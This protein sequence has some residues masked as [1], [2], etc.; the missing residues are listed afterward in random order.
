[1]ERF[2]FKKRIVHI[3]GCK[4]CL[5]NPV[6]LHLPPGTYRVQLIGTDHGGRHNA[7]SVWEKREAGEVAE[8]AA[9]ESKEEA[10]RGFELRGWM[11][12][13]AVLSPYVMPHP[14]FEGRYYPGQGF[15]VE[16]G[17]IHRDADEALACSSVCV[18]SLLN[19]GSVGFATHQSPAGSQNVRDGLSLEV[20]RIHSEPATGN[21]APR[22][23]QKTFNRFRNV[24]RLPQKAPRRVLS[25]AWCRPRGMRT[26]VFGPAQRQ[27]KLDFAGIRGQGCNR[28]SG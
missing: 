1:M 2:D 18:F 7:W 10:L 12:G 22:S 6:R 3:D 17:R 25:E 27:K 28:N 21:P 11:N 26:K 4:N 15:F 5:G 9:Q 8:A 19:F 23:F 24:L 20:Q 14:P 16:D 13:Y